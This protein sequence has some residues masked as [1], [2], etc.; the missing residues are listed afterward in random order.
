M[1]SK[2]T[3]RYIDEQIFEVFTILLGELDSVGKA[4]SSRIT[5]LEL[6]KD[7]ETIYNSSER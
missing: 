5:R 6:E 2:K 3:K 4:L 1:K 7:N